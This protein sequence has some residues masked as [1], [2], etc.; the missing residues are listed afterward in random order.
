MRRFTIIAVASAAALALAPASALARHH[1]SHHSRVHHARVHHRRFGDLASSTTATSTPAETAGTVD[2]FSGGI[3]TI[4]LNGGGTIT[5]AVTNDTELECTSASAPSGSR[6]DGDQGSSGEDQ[7]SSGE[8]QG[9]NEASEDVP[10]TTANLVPGTVVR[11]A[12]LR[13]SSAGASW[14]KVE[15]SI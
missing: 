9:E 13:V 14:E 2:S 4:A 3:L 12:E 1:K 6:D 5:G 15:L 8:D 10:C 11:G 7:G